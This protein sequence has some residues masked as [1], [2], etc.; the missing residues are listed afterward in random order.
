MAPESEHT[1]PTEV[2]VDRSN[3]RGLTHPLR[4]RL[5]G[6]LRA[7]GPATASQLAKEYDT[8]SGD[9]SY[10]LRQLSRF[11]FIEEDPERGTKR[12]RWWRAAHDR[13]VFDELEMDPEDREIARWLN[14]QVVG[15]TVERLG[16]AATNWRDWPEEWQP[17]FTASDVLLDLTTAEVEDLKHQIIT[18]IDSFRPHRAQDTAGE[19]AAEGRRVIAV[20]YQLFLHE[21]PP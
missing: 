21:P 19:A 1:V 4:V 14:N 11:G 9:V 20:Q 13:T 2:V 5:I 16:R 6:R 12:E 15:H 3:L 17:T 10:H 8:T 7:E 18:L